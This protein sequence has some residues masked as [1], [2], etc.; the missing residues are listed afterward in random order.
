VFDYHR[1]FVHQT[2]NPIAAVYFRVGGVEI[3]LTLCASDVAVELFQQ[4]IEFG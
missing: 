3:E 4:R 2:T 1:W